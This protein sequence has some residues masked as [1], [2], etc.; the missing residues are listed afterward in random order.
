MTEQ[1]YLNYL[2]Q[3]L[4]YYTTDNNFVQLQVW[5][6]GSKKND[7]QANVLFKNKNY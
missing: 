7:W 1:K 5:P 4:S 2:E 6:Q 3:A